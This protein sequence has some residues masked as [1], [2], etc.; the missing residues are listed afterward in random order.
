MSYPV[1]STQV[2]QT[3]FLQ[4]SFL[5]CILV[6][7]T[8]CPLRSSSFCLRALV[9]P[10]GTCLSICLHI[11]RPDCYP[12]PVIAST[13]FYGIL[14]LFSFYIRALVF[15]PS[16]CRSICLHIKRPG[17]CPCFHPFR[18]H[19]RSLHQ[20][21]SRAS[22]SCT[23]G[24]HYIRLRFTYALLCFHQA[25]VFQYV[26]IYRHPAAFHVLTLSGGIAGDCINC[27][28]KHPCLVHEVNITFVFFLLTRS[29]ASAKQLCVNKFA[30]K[31]ALQLSM[32]SPFPWHPRSL[33]QLFSRASLSCTRGVH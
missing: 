10:P 21:F 2:V 31:A 7:Y 3:F 32:I 6:L 16:S 12:S 4:Q 27:F 9:L 23:R 33:H 30:H 18:W 14:V 8:T 15:P 5:T 24:V 20:L 25:A 29:F 28:L 11:K 26:C 19:P 22:S 17:C 1:S 13:V